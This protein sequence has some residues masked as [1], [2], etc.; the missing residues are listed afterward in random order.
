MVKQPAKRD[1][2]RIR[3]ETLRNLRQYKHLSDE[4]F[5]EVYQNLVAGVIVEKT[6]ETRIQD[7]LDELAQDYDLDDLNANDKL[8]L[9]NMIQAML[10]IEDLEQLA[11]RIRSQGIDE[12]AVELLGRINRQINELSERASNIQRDLGITRRIRKESSEQSVVDFIES[13]KAKAREFYQEKM[14]YI[15]CPNCGTLLATIWTLNKDKSDPSDR[16][17]LRC[18]RKMPDGTECGTR[19]VFRIADNVNKE[20]TNSADLMP[21][22]MR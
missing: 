3:K 19:V 14:Q 22:G 8:M 5:E 4:E 1:A 10:Q 2:A 6:F 17:V 11:Y 7:K 9:R 18:K 20:M 21:E 16:V 13:L 15:Y 12:K